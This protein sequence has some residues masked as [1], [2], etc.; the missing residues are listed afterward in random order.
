MAGRFADVAVRVLLAGLFGLRLATAVSLAL[1]VAFYLELDNPSW[2]GTSAVIVTQ[3]IVGSSFQKGVFRLIGT[4]A[5]AF[6]AVAL[7]AV[8]P[9]DRSA[10]LFTKIAAPF[11]SQC[12]TITAALP[13]PRSP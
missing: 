5:G 3:P 7:T 13:D 9:Q 6:A 2:A 12:L 11:C 10:L 4:V 1:F 8:F